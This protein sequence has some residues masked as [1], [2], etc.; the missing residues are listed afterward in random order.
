ML[1]LRTDLLDSSKISDISIVLITP[2]SCQQ[3]VMLE[4]F[5]YFQG[6]VPGTERATLELQAWA[7]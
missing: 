3:L 5:P 6:A 7:A 4:H 1:V 2:I